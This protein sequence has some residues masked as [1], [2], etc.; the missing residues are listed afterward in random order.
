MPFYRHFDL[1]LVTAL[2]EQLLQAFDGLEIGPLQESNLEQIPEQQGV[3]QLHQ[4]DTLV[5][6]GKADNSLRSRLFDH[7]RKITGRANISVEEMGFKC[8]SLSTNWAAYA[9][10]QIL[11]AHYQAL[12]MSPWNGNGF[13]QHDPGRRR[14]ETDKPPDGFDY[15]YPIREDWVCSSISGGK[16][17]CKDLLQELKKELPYLLRYERGQPDCEHLEVVLPADKLT[18]REILK[19]IGQHLEGWQA[20]RFPSHIILYKEQRHYKYGTILWPE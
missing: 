7:F 1:D 2:K 13:G 18:A 5:Y 6:V 12:G 4:Q 17:N 11:I 3:Y 19:I 14:E 15:Q 20:T 9:P 10:E 8:L 16:W